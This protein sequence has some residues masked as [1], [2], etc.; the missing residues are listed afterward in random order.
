MEHQVCDLLVLVG[1]FYQKTFH[2]VKDWLYKLQEHCLPDAVIA[3]VGNKNE[4]TDLRQVDEHMGREYAESINAIFLE[5]S[6]VTADN[7]DLLFGKIA[8]RHP[9][10]KHQLVQTERPPDNQQCC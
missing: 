4:L 7:V 10:W 1:W 8:K 9:P 5:V 3:I 6:A 2:N